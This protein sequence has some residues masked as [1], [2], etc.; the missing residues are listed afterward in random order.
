MQINILIKSLIS[1]IPIFG[2]AYLLYTKFSNPQYFKNNLLIIPFITTT[3]SIAYIYNNFF[4][5]INIADDYGRLLFILLILFGNG[6]SFVVYFVVQFLL[7]SKLYY[8]DIK[9]NG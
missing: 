8:K 3:C 9:I 5:G 7:L 1:I 6:F 2:I 4:N